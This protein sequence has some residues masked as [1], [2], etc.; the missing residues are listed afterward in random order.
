MSETEAAPSLKPPLL[1]DYRSLPGTYDELVEADGSLREHWRP[2]ISSLQRLSPEEMAAR[3]DNTRRV[4]R[5]HGATYNVYSDGDSLGRPWP[6]DLLPLVIPA[7]EWRRIEAGLIQRAHLLNLIL[8][9]IYGPQKLF[10]DGLLPPALLYAN[11]GFLRPCHGIRPVAQRF[12]FLH[13]VDLARAADGSWW[14]LADRTQAPSGAGYT[15]ENRLVLSRVFPDEFRESHVQ[16]L[17]A[18]FQSA[19]DTLRALAP[20]GRENPNV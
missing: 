2:L 11:P 17:A 5:E 10:R 3:Q 12:L 9:D 4:I 20:F 8:A 18:F 7:G 15:L 14:V 13:A 1:G 6:L 16:R 19:R